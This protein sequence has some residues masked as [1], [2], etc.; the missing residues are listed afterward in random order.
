MFVSLPKRVPYRIFLE[1]CI[2]WLHQ[3]QHYFQKID[4][5]AVI[6]LRWRDKL[7]LSSQVHIYAYYFIWALTFITWDIL[8]IAGHLSSAI[9]TS[10][11]S[12]CLSAISLSAAISKLITFSYWFISYIK[13]LGK[14]NH[15]FR[16]DNKLRELYSLTCCNTCKSSY[17]TWSNT[18]YTIRHWT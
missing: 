3:L 13:S 2:Y 14:V 1:S 17:E 15:A 4:L 11:Y 8:Y 12:F 5:I 6:L 9:L 18:S 16:I 10:S 7:T